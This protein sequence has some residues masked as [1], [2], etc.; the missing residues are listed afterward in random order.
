MHQSRLKPSSLVARQREL[1]VQL[2]RVVVSGSG[3]SLPDL[4]NL[5]F[6][7]AVPNGQPIWKIWKN[8]VCFF[9][10]IDR[11][12][13]WVLC[14]ANTTIAMLAL[15]YYGQK[16]GFDIWIR[17]STMKPKLFWIATS[18][19]NKKK[20]LIGPIL[21]LYYEK[22]L[23]SSILNSKQLRFHGVRPNIDG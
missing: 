12:T 2:L 5:A 14:Q 8:C 4:M 1:Q 13:L 16:P 6:L 7:S 21:F 17:M 18:V 3:E 10:K 23:V 19:G 15:N 20:F 9:Y 11:L 22:S